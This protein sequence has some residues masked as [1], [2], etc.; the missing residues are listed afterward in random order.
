MNLD[1]R[2]LRIEDSPHLRELEKE[3]K[4]HRLMQL[5]AL[6][7]LRLKGRE[8]GDLSQ[9]SKSELLDIIGTDKQ[10]YEQ[11]IKGFAAR[12]RSENYK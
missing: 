7:T 3:K 9:L 2:L 6:G 1:N 8:V 11:A 10:S 12:R 5:V 4:G